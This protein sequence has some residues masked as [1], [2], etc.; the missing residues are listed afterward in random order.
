MLG[1]EWIAAVLREAAVAL[2]AGRPDLLAQSEVWRGDSS[3]PAGLLGGGE[4]LGRWRSECWMGYA[5]RARD[6]SRRVV[7]DIFASRYQ[8]LVRPEVDPLRRGA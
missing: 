2:G 6:K 3:L 7:R 5:H 4:I 8:L 1:R